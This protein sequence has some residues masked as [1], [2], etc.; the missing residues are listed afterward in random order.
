LCSGSTEIG[1]AKFNRELEM[2]AQFRR[3]ENSFAFLSDC[4]SQLQSILRQDQEFID[5][6]LELDDWVEEG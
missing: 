5:Q 2:V 1:T 6:L 3:K 4:V